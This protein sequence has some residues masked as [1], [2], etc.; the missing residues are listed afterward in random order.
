MDPAAA[1]AD[2]QRRFEPQLSEEY[3][4]QTIVLSSFLLVS[5]LVS[6]GSVALRYLADAF[7]CV[8]CNCERGNESDEEQQAFPI[9]S[10]DHSSALA[11]Q[12]AHLF[13]GILDDDDPVSL[14]RRSD[15]ESVY[16]PSDAVRS[17]LV[18]SVEQ[19]VF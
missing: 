14:D 2:L 16:F 13:V 5:L 12:L 15:A 17:A 4:R 8:S 3:H 7:W 11:H 18:W 1:I 6:V 10:R 9:Q 19:S